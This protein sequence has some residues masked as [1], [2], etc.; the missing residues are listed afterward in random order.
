MSEG[1]DLLRRLRG[2]FETQAFMRLI[3]AEVV[4]VEPGS[5]E[6]ALAVRTDLTQHSGVVHGGVV[7]ALADNAAGGAASTLMPAGHAAITAE[8]K[9]NFVAPAAGERLIAR[10]KVVRAGK[11]LSVCESRVFARTGEG[12]TLCAAALVTLVPLALAKGG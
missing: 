9:I 1:Q 10:A 6:L 5:C 4:A 12:E 3:G 7:A 2:V 11:N 8:Y